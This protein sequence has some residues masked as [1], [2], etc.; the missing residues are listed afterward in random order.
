[1]K[2]SIL[3][4]MKFLLSIRILGDAND[5]EDLDEHDGSTLTEKIASWGGMSFKIGS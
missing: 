2:D 4:F 3:Q 5:S 1:M